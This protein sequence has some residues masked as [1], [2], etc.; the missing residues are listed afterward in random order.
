MEDERTRLVSFDYA[1]DLDTTI[2]R[3][4]LRRTKEKWP[5]ALEKKTKERESERKM[6]PYA[7]GTGQEEASRSGR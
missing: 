6:K 3:M 5:I 7:R 2:P 4:N 1:G